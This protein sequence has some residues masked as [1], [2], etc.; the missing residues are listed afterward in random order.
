[1]HLLWLIFDSALDHQ[2]KGKLL[3]TAGHV[4]GVVLRLET[5]RSTL[6]G[7]GM[8]ATESLYLCGMADHHQKCTRTSTQAEQF[9]AAKFNQILIHP[10]QMD[11]RGAHLRPRL[12]GLAHLNLHVQSTNDAFLARQGVLSS[13]QAAAYAHPRRVIKA[14]FRGDEDLEVPINALALE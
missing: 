5:A 10:L 2:Q 14:P 7:Q 6:T 1:M 9:S 13:H 4:Q 11:R 12:L 3:P 8:P